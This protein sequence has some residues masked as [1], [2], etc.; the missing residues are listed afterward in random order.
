MRLQLFYNKRS[1]FVQGLEA[2][3]VNVAVGRQVR[4][5]SRRLDNSQVRGSADDSNR[6]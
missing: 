1:Q 4:F 3:L 2:E 5:S 6:V